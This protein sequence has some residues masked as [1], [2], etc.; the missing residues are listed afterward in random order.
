MSFRR[1]EKL[2]VARGKIFQL[3]KWINENNGHVV[4]PARIINSVY[5]D[6]KSYSMYN[7]S[8]EGVT[9]RKKIRL[10]SY[11]NNFAF[12][13]KV[14]KE[15]KITSV[16][17]RY[18]LSEPITNPHNLVKLGIHDISYGICH[19]VLNV[20]YERSYYKINN[21]RLTIDKKI[22][23]R[24]VNN[25]K[26]SKFSTIDNFDIVEIKYGLNQ[27]TDDISKNFPFERTRFSK[28]CRGIEF[29][30]LNYCNEI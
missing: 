24:V 28:Y 9:P 13:K 2:K 22:I 19:P 15:I 18:K 17:G 14:N 25:G 12:N 30:R 1:E 27:S 8:I 6:N 26:I 20:I 11:D 5:F 23:Y 21:A 3:K 16:E 29:T 10:R 4:Y 7:E